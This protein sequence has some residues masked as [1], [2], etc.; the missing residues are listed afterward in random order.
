MKTATLPAVRVRPEL[1]EQLERVLRE[2]ESLSSFVETS[3]REA[4]ERRIAQEAFIARGRRAME[5]YRRSGV[6]F[7]LDEVRAHLQARLDAAVAQRR[8][9]SGAK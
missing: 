9:T 8:R 5:E 3:V 4:A 2:G 1:R 7:T 6:S